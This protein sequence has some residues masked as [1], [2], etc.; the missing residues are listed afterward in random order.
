MTREQLTLTLC[1]RLLAIMPGAQQEIAALTALYDDDD[2]SREAGLG[3]R[4]AAS[5]P[6]RGGQGAIVVLPIH[7]PIFNRDMGPYLT[8]VDRLRAEFRRMVTNPAISAIV[9]D[10][11][12]PGGMLGGIPEFAAELRRPRDTRVVAVVNDLAGSAAYWLAS[13]ADEVVAMPSALVGS[14][15]IIAMHTD[16][17]E[18]DAMAGVRTTLISVGE[19]KTDGSPFEPLS[20][21]ARAN[22]QQTLDHFYRMFVSDV[23]RF[24]R[25]P[26][27]TIRS[28]WKADVFTAADALKLGM[29]DRIGS[30]EGTL[31]RLA[32]RPVGI[33]A[34]AAE[35]ETRRRRARR[36]AVGA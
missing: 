16:V 8:S 27:S 7:G 11:D 33:Q 30:M 1:D 25:V 10:I 35:D 18:A 13:A 32:R 6:R 19:G 31:S 26:R 12:S 17:S 5:T 21:R 9:L 36:L 22:I 15:G 29:I 34:Y 28:T 2:T 4:A 23:S 20:D 3:V 24:R 14:I